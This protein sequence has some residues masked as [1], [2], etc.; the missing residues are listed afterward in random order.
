MMWIH[1]ELVRRGGWESGTAQFPA[2]VQSAPFMASCVCGG[3]E[4]SCEIE[5]NCWIINLLSYRF[6][7]Q[8]NIPLGSQY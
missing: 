8:I 1:L 4:E 3:L 7:D 6:P 2:A 5:L